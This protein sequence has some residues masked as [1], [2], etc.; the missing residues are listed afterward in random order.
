MDVKQCKFVMNLIRNAKTNR[1]REQIRNLQCGS[2]GN[3]YHVCCPEEE[4]LQ[5][6]GPNIPSKFYMSLVV[7]S[8]D[9]YAILN[10]S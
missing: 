5:V 6:R 7:F 2:K 8:V 3:T 4:K 10:F 9:V 1:D